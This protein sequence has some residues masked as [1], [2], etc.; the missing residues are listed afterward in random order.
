MN[1]STTVNYGEADLLEKIRALGFVKG[2]L[3]LFL[4]THPTS[5]VALAYY[6]DTVNALERLTEEYQS[7]YGPLVAGAS[8]S[9]DK[10]SWIGAPWPW[11]RN[12]DVKDMKEG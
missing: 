5:G 1:K 8:V 9:T 12:S 3:E 11:Q 2:E 10:W 4:D 6:H 7:N